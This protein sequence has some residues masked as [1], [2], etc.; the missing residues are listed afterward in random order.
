MKSKEELRSELRAAGLRKK[1]AKRLAEASVG[2]RAH[3]RPLPQAAVTEIEELRSAL[4]SLRSTARGRTPKAKRPRA[5][6]SSRSGRGSG[7]RSARTK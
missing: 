6:T 3:G 1:S 2:A 5:R 7:R 4:R